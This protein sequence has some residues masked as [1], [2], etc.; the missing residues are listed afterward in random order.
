MSVFYISYKYE[1]RDS[2]SALA[3]L[4]R[5]KGHVVH[6]DMELAVGVAWRDKLAKDLLESDAVVVLWTE[7]TYRSQFVPAEVGAARA[8]PHIALLPV[9]VGD[10]EKPP[11][12]DDLNVK[13]IPDTADDTLRDLVDLLDASLQ[14]H[15]QYSGRRKKGSPRVFISHRHKDEKIVRALLDCIELYFHVDPS[16]IR[17]T[18]VQP[19]RL[20]VGQETADR[21]RDEIANAEVVLGILTTDTLESS[22]VAFELGSAWGQKVWTCPLLAAGADQS[23]IP[24]PIRGLSPLFLTD[25]R[26]CHQLLDDMKGFT[27]LKERNHEGYTKLDDRVLTL[28]EAASA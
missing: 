27:S 4:L 9:V 3:E 22:Y 18:S 19:Y 21:L 11:F 28:V 1:D 15:Q 20:P 16:D 10:V 17:C 13:R 6:F 5:E 23:H 12:L 14:K 24:D 25:R 8:S 7:N 26:E 2:A